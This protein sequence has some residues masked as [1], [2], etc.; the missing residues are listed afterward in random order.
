[1]SLHYVLDGYNII[2][3]IPSLNNKKLKIAREQLLN[4]IEIYRPH[5]SYRNSITVVFDGSEETYGNDGTYGYNIQ[6]VFTKRQ[7]ADDYIKL[8]IEKSKNAKDFCVV[9][10]DKDI[11]FYC[12]ALGCKVIDVDTFIAKG[13]KSGIKRHSEQNDLGYLGIPQ[14]ELDKITEELRLKWLK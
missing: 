9:S 7:S 10:D 13:K 11:R 8:L 6:I 3:K 5:G 12:Q 14:V 4:F 1:M 2:K